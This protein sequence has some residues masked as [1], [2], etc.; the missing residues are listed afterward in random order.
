MFHIRRFEPKDQDSVAALITEI[1]SEEFRDEAKAYP[2]DDLKHIQQTY[3]GL[4]EA[5]FVATNGN[6]IIGTVAIK[7]EDERVALLRR[8]FVA[9]PFRKQQIGFKLMDRALEFCDEVGYHEIV[10]KTTSQMK[11]AIKICENRGFA[12]RAKLPM[13]SVELLKFSLS[14]RDRIK[15]KKE[16]VS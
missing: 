5:F 14:L 13:G 10:F 4:G 12:P 1:M 3:G 8:L 16:K 2:T 6:Q 9:A 11:G 15:H 7:K